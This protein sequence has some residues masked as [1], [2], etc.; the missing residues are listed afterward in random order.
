MLGDEQ[1]A[2]LKQADADVAAPACLLALEQRPPRTSAPNKPPMMS[3]AEEP[4]RSGRP[5]G[6][7]M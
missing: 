7:V 5:V 2:V 3:L 6:P 1:Q 4:T